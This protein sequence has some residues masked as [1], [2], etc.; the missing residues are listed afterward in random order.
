M[1]LGNRFRRPF[2]KLGLG[3]DLFHPATRRG[4]VTLSVVKE[5][6]NFLVE[7]VR[8][9]IRMIHAETTGSAVFM[10]NGVSRANGPARIPRGGLDIDFFERGALGHLAVG[11]GVHAATTRDGQCVDR[12]A[13]VQSV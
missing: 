11:H 10:P 8:S 12:M 5:S 3:G 7:I 9:P 6:G 4:D 13:F 2:A 1:T